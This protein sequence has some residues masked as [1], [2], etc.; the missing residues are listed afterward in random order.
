MVSPPLISGD[1]ISLSVTLRGLAYYAKTGARAFGAA[2]FL[3]ICGGEMN[4]RLDERTL[5]V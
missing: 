5:P 4:E 2:I 3:V 1:H